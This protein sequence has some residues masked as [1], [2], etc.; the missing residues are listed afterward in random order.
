[1]APAQCLGWPLRG[2]PAPPTL[3][4]EVSDGQVA[5]VVAVSA[6]S[7]ALHLR[8]QATGTEGTLD[9]YECQYGAACTGTPPPG[10]L[11]LCGKSD[12]DD[13]CYVSIAYNKSGACTIPF[14]TAKCIFSMTPCFT[15]EEGFCDWKTLPD[16]TIKAYCAPG[17][18]GR[19][20]EIDSP[21]NI[22]SCK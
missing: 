5:A 7:T 19:Y 20:Q 3:F 11:P 21:T 8:G 13:H 18:N 15:Y 10:V 4:G 2:G 14:Y 9:G 6:V 12:Y 22:A 17:P 1:M 16:G